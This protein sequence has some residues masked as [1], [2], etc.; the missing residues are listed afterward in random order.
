MAAV[1]ALSVSVLLS[2]CYWKQALNDFE[3]TGGA[4]LPW[5]CKGVNPADN[6][7]V[8]DDCVGFSMRMDVAV[9]DAQAYPTL[10]DALDAGAQ[11]LAGQPE[12][13]GYAVL[14]P[15]ASAQFAPARPN[16]LLYADDQPGS[17][18]AG[19]AWRVFGAEPAG[20][21]GNRDV[22]QFY[23]PTGHWWLPG[24]IIRGYENHPNVFAASHPCLADGVTLTSTTDACFT[25][26]HTE[27]FEVVVTNDDGYAAEGIG[28]LVDGL[29]ALPNMNVHVVAPLA[30][31][32]GSG[33]QTTLPGYSTFVDSE[34]TYFTSGG[35]PATA[36]SSTEVDD[37][38]ADP[39]FN[40]RRDG[41]GSPADAVI[42]ALDEMLLSPELVLSGINKGQN[43]TVP[44]TNVSGTVG[45][46]RTA[47]RMGI[48]AIGTSQGAKTGAATAEDFP[49]GVAATLAYLEEWRLGIHQTG[50]DNVP[51]INIP[52]CQ[53][54]TSIRGTRRGLVVAT[55]IANP[56][57]YNGQD[58]ASTETEI[59]TDQDA[60]ANGF[61]SIADV[62]A[63]PL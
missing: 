39:P 25:A 33:E 43:M 22:W 61:V 35:Y 62:T 29:V 63:N 60:F 21:D 12:G 41:S 46:A 34:A 56:P 26:S 52:T 31:Q 15:D 16:I 58:C 45:A 6:L 20:F 17:R 23:G 30:N 57:G 54:G 53:P 37:P 49:S 19:V 47:R 44:I 7:S 11:I 4:E 42:W 9:R 59:V 2:G 1:V 50:E 32:S 10:Q 27:P 18:L 38:L 36:V 8:Q 14:R 5:W 40:S 24:W 55:G 48:P 13:I 51:N 28:A 3:R